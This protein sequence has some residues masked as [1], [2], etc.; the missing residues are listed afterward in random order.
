MSRNARSPGGLALRLARVD[1]KTVAE[2]DTIDAVPP[3]PSATGV[4]PE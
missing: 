3:S 1:D 2:A 4:V